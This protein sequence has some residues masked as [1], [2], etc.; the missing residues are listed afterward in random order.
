MQ[1]LRTIFGDMLAMKVEEVVVKIQHHCPS[2]YRGSDE[3]MDLLSYLSIMGM[4]SQCAL[5][6][7]MHMCM[8]NQR[9]IND[10]Y[11]HG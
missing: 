3:L 11:G 4:V 10:A 2:L 9:A 6:R 8:V 7:M 5:I 1:S